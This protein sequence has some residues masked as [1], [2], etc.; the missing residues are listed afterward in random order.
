MPRVTFSGDFVFAPSRRVR[1]AFMG[2][3]TY[4]V[5]RAAASA[6]HAAGRLDKAPQADAT[7]TAE[8]GETTGRK[9]GRR[10]AD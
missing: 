6:A 2:G 5:T 1:Q 8:G 10:G 4:L 7:D 3:K 9:R